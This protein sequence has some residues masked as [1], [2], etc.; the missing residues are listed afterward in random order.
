MVLTNDGRV[1]G[2]LV[3]RLSL[4]VLNL[5]HDALAVDDLAVDDMLLVQMRCGDGRNEELRSVGA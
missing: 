2:R 1:L 3:T 4:Q 5:A